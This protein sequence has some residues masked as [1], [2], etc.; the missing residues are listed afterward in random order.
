[1]KQGG[2]DWFPFSLEGSHRAFATAPSVVIR[3]TSGGEPWHI[4]ASFS[5]TPFSVAR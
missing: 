5:V 3:I 2:K 4:D 1:M